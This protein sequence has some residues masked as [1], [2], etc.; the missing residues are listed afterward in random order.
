MPNGVGTYTAVASF[1]GSTSYAPASSAVTFAIASPSAEILGDGQPGFWST[2]TGWTTSTQGL[3]GGS[4]VSN[5]TNGSKSSQAAWWFS[6]P[7][8]VYE[9]DMTWPAGS[10]LTTKLGL[11]LY[12]GVG[13]WI[14]QI[15]VNEQVAPSDFQRSGGR[16]EATRQFQT[17]EQH[18]PYL[19]VEQPDR[20]GHRG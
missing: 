8:G 1:A 18:L 4:L 15:P 11:D 13:N 5:T 16:V 9:I 10:N 6:M 19:D 12:D 14:G 7:A 2:S 20:R 17:H 3:D